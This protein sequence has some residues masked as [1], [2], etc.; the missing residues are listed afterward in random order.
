MK[1]TLNLALFTALLFIGAYLKYRVAPRWY[2]L[3]FPG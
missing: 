1:N 3:G 2:C